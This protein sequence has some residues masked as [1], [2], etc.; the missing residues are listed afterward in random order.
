MCFESVCGILILQLYTNACS[1]LWKIFFF[2][3]VYEYICSLHFVEEKCILQGGFPYTHF[4]ILCLLPYKEK[5]PFTLSL[6]KNT[7][8]LPT[9]NIMGPCAG[10]APVRL[11]GTE[12]LKLTPGFRCDLP[13]ATYRRLSIPQTCCLCFGSGPAYHPSGPWAPSSITCLSSVPH[14]ISP[15]DITHTD[16]IPH[17]LSRGV[18]S[19]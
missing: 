11:S 3:W 14:P 9:P 19:S 6:K 4:K 17:W 10:H 15:F 12:G 16:P 8:L 13:S 5:P 2:N 1:H 18:R 7:G